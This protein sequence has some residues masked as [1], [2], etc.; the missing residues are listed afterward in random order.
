MDDGNRYFFDS[1]GGL[2]MDRRYFVVDAFTH[3]RFSGNAAAVVLDS[4]GLDDETM[5][6]IATEFNL[7]ETT[8]VRPPNS[9]SADFQFRWFTPT[10][11]VRMCGHATIAGAHALLACG[12]IQQE[13]RESASFVVDSLSGPLGLH[14]DVLPG[15][16]LKRMIWLDLP[17]PRWTTTTL[18][19]DLLAGVLNLPADSFD[20]TMP[21]VRTQDADLLVFVNHVAILNEA[22]PDFG[23]L[24]K[25]HEDTDIRGLCLATTR[26]LSPSIHVQSR[27]FAPA[28]GVDE[29]PVTGSVHGPLA[30]YLVRHEKV[31]LTDGLA[32]LQCAQARAGGRGGVVFALV[33]PQEDGQYEVRIGGKAV[34]TMVGKITG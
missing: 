31:P 34:T 11:E 7:S 33:Q 4:E 27:F 26:T 19:L 16:P 30:A 20:A 2:R 10:A 15:Q 21:P 8:F 18:D 3:D 5:Q 25:I 14:I 17:R 32:G 1:P 28:A 13:G 29:D 9:E 23:R 12:R 24:K 6:A 22:Q